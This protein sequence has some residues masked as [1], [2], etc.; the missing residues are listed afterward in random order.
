MDIESI[1]FLVKP[2]Y[3]SIWLLQKWGSFFIIFRKHKMWSLI[4]DRDRQVQLNSRLKDLDKMWN[5]V[6]N[7][8]FSNLQWYICSDR[9]SWFSRLWLDLSRVPTV[10]V[11][12]ARSNIYTWREFIQSDMVFTDSYERMRMQYS[13]QMNISNFVR[14]PEELHYCDEPDK[15]HDILWHIPFLMQDD[16]SKMYQE[17]W[18]LFTDTFD[19]LWEQKA[20]EVDN[21]AWFLTEVWLINENNTL[22]AFWATLYSS[23]WELEKAF[24]SSTQRKR[25]WLNEFL[26][27]QERFDRKDLMETYYIIEWID[28]IVFILNEYRKMNEITFT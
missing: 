27:H 2:T 24:A 16:Y 9:I 10:K 3:S 21:M 4:V 13:K 22:K 8:Q 19:Q 5:T 12:N 26:S 14:T 20:R 18:K 28:E 11:L 25:F 15:F 1:N 7:I 23:S 17:F 6:F